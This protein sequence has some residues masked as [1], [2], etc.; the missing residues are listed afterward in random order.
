MGEERRGEM[1]GRISLY[2]GD[3]RLVEAPGCARDQDWLGSAGPGAGPC[4]FLC[5]WPNLTFGP[6]GC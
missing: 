5:C 3:P 6:L 4:L 1:G 2:L